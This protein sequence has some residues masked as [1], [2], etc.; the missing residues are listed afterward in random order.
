MARVTA[1]TTLAYPLVLVAAAACYAALGS[2]VAILPGYVPRLGGTAT[3]V[4]LA[5][6][7]PALTGAGARPLGGRWADRHGPAPVMIGGAVV[8]SVAALPGVVPR[9]PLLLASR[10][11]V[12]AGEAVMMAAT[13]LWLLRLAGPA[14][15][16]RALGH[17]GLANYAGLAVGPALARLVGGDHPARVLVL[18]AALPLVAAAVAAVI[19]AGRG[20]PAARSGPAAGVSVLLRATARPGLGLLLVNVGYVAV[21]GFAAA[22]ASARQVQLGALAVPLFGAGVIVSRT[23][24][25]WV[26]DRCGAAATL[27]G[28]VVAEAVGLVGVAASSSFPVTIAALLVLAVGQGLAVP[29]LGLLALAA[30]PPADHG[31]AGGLFF[32]Y[33]D[34]GVGLG[35][36]AVGLVAEYAD[37]TAALLASGAAVLAAAPAALLGTDRGRPPRLGPDT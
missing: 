22:A 35:G 25:G 11:A 4:G 17:V 30:V 31:A 5:V 23:A 18:A 7:A 27:C 8:M 14:H 20:D 3:L 26:P 10:L 12:G 24:L 28:A 2:V 6:G 13:V 29:A 21:L 16:G 15:R 34:A 32:G 36:P 1:T 9:L 19:G 33:F 37:A